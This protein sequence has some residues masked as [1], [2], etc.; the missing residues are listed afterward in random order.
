METRNKL[1][2]YIDTLW[3]AVGELVVALLVLAGF[4]VAR[5]FGMEVTVYKVITGAL[6]GGAV[7]VANFLILSVAV[8]RA[9]NGYIAGIGDKEMT[10]EEADEYAKKNSMNVQLA[11]TKSYIIRMV[12][13]LGSLI[14]ALFTKQFNVLATAIPLIMYRPILYVTDFIKTK[15]K[16]KRGD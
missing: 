2:E 9:V 14:L 16:A 11:M 4:L 6:L 10:E 12:L 13:M 15:S 7:T 1:S 5:A 8:N 3:L